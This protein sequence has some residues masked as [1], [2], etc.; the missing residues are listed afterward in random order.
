MSPTLYIDFGLGGHSYVGGIPLN[1][2][3]CD[4]MAA[5]WML[6][7]DAAANPQDA[8]EVAVDKSAAAKLLDVPVTEAVT[9]TENGV[10]TGTLMG[11]AQERLRQLADGA[12]LSLLAIL[13]DNSG[14][15]GT[16]QGMTVGAYRQKLRSGFF[17]LVSKWHED[18]LTI[19]YP[20]W[21]LQA[22]EYAPYSIARQL[23][24]I[25]Q[26][27]DANL[28]LLAELS[29]A[30]SPAQLAKLR[31]EF[32]P[33]RLIFDMRNPLALLRLYPEMT[34]KGGLP[35][36]DEM[37]PVMQRLLP[38]WASYKVFRPT[39]VEMYKARQVTGNTSR[40]VVHFDLT[41]EHHIPVGGGLSP[42]TGS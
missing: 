16:P 39:T 35:I 34:R 37:R 12:H 40:I 9:I 22:A 15:L 29:E 6:T 14:D 27:G 24:Q 4:Q 8:R 11:R 10:K 19:T 32:A 3:L 21:F 30:L 13:P 5:A 7:G 26:A 18:V 2:Q 23:R 20:P 17:P 33:A 38:D 28:N 36:T 31:N 1:N 41:G 42:L 25:E